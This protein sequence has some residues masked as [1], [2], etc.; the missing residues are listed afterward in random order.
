[1]GTGRRG[2]AG[3]LRRPADRRGPRSYKGLWVQSLPQ[4]WQVGW[5]TW[6]PSPSVPDVLN[7][8]QG[9][10]RGPPRYRQQGQAHSWSRNTLLFKST[11]E[12]FPSGPVAVRAPNAKGG[13]V[14]LP[15]QGT[16]SHMPTLR[17][18]VPQLKLPRAATET[19]CS[20]INLLFLKIEHTWASPL[21]GFLF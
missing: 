7:L 12:D 6:R 19:R 17:V 13:P 20:Q 5:N 21:R 3:T 8:G 11:R 4:V 15:G 10:R 14:S 9:Q 16:R 1:M 2:G 18:H